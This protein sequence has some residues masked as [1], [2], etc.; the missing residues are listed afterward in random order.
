[1]KKRRKFSVNTLVSIAK[2]YNHIIDWART[3]PSSYYAALR[4]GCMD[5][6][7]A[8]MKRL[9]SKPWTKENVIQDA[10]KYSNPTEWSRVS[11]AWSY[12]QRHGLLKTCTSHM[13]R[14]KRSSFSDL[15]I[16]NIALQ[17]KSRTEWMVNSPSSYSVACKRKLLDKCSGHMVNLGGSSFYEKT[18]LDAVKKHFPSA[19]PS[20]FGR[21]SKGDKLKRFQVDIYVPEIRKGIE[22]DGSYWHSKQGLRIG[23]PSWTDLE[24]AEYPKI[25]DQFFSDRNISIMHVL[26]SDWIKDKN[27]VIAKALLFLGASNVNGS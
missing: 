25:K 22:F 24:I 12:A 20:W 14:K 7:T 16:V 15:D 9:V 6:C 3:D 11:T 13:I 4:W 17:Y 19:Q 2:Q 21:A 1:M 5:K 10:K 18:L 27:S 23:R 8:H 26:E